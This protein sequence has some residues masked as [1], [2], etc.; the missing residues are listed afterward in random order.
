MSG[1]FYPDAVWLGPTIEAL[2]AITT[3]AAPVEYKIRSACRAIV[4][5][6]NSFAVWML[7]WAPGDDPQG[8]PQVLGCECD[9]E[10]LQEMVKARNQ[11]PYASWVRRM[12]LVASPTR[13]SHETVIEPSFL[14]EGRRYLIVCAPMLAHGKVLGFLVVVTASTDKRC[15]AEWNQLRVTARVLGMALQSSIE[16]QASG[17]S[18]F[19]VMRLK[20]LGSTLPGSSLMINDSGK[21]VQVFNG[22]K[23]VPHLFRIG[24]EWVLKF[25]SV[26]Q[27]KEHE[28]ALALSM[29][30]KSVR[31]RIYIQG[32]KN[33][34]M[35]HSFEPVL[36]STSSKVRE[37]VCF[38]KDVTDIL[39]LQAIIKNLKER[40]ASTGC[41][42]FLGM[43]E[44]ASKEIDL[45]KSSHVKCTVVSIELENSSS[46][47]QLPG[48]PG[49]D[50]LLKGLVARMKALLPMRHLIARR[51]EFSFVV[52]AQSG[53]RDPTS[54]E[55]ANS[56]LESMHQPILA[57]RGECVM[58]VSIGYASFPTNGDNFQTILSGSDIAAIHAH[59]SGKNKALPFQQDMV[60]LSLDR[61]QLEARLH[62]AVDSEEF[63]LVFQPKIRL[64]DG[65]VSGVEAL[66]RWSGE[67]AIEPAKFIP[68]AEE[69]GLISYIGE[70]VLRRACATATRWSELGYR[71]PISINVSTR[72][73]YAKDF[74]AIVSE[75]LSDTKCDPSL[76]ELEIT[77]GAVFFDPDASVVNFKKLKELGLGISI[78]DFGIGFSNLSYLKN[79]SVDSIK[80]DRSFV[81]GLPDDK[82]NVAIAKA[83]I[84]IARA[85]DLK[86]TAEG[87]E[88]VRCLNQL[89]VLG[90]D[91]VQGFYFSKALNENELIN[92][93][94]AYRYTMS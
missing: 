62:R 52:I 11:A 93:Y 55:L 13:D 74:H 19:Q 83:I 81:T 2:A 71:I 66:L 68:I 44:N 58:N 33:L 57:G 50:I 51:G 47:L 12:S 34:V 94:N 63:T 24:E 32:E 46:E 7:G 17:T 40:D 91:E 35:E 65:S 1:G 43:T 56:F 37:V 48:D 14:F 92:W 3:S 26:D 45:A 64:E 15:D 88:D 76:I 27:Q 82:G 8:K 38:I 42:T 49:I 31:C 87:V 80:I 59:R 70:W 75:V 29:K 54:S 41:M 85:M 60:R 67:N 25:S 84:S 39:R 77:E 90:C 86:V 69:C 28:K 6:V 72:Q 22:Q 18:D 53:D 10:Y 5:H 9:D 78:D 79:L 73:F 30:G 36:I 89:K 23:P 21:I 16:Y 4:D 61:S 20:A